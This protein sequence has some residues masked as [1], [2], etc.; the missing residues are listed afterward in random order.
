M[1]ISVVQKDQHRGILELIPLILVFFLHSLCLSGLGLP[2]SI[3]SLSYRLEYSSNQLIPFRFF[4]LSPLCYHW[5]FSGSSPSSRASIIRLR[6]LS[7][8]IR[9]CINHFKSFIFNHPP[10]QN[11]LNSFLILFLPQPWLFLPTIF[12]EHFISTV[13]RYK[14]IPHIPVSLISVRSFSSIFHR[15]QDLSHKIEVRFTIWQAKSS[16]YFIFLE[17]RGCCHVL[18]SET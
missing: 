13:I 1:C 5:F 6:F 17:R 18:L 16:S 8:P 7:S 15:L 4:L 12:R 11:C 14:F 3:S 2:R 9:I 10:I